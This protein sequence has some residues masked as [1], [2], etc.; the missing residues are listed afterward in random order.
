MPLIVF[1][2]IQPFSRSWYLG[3]GDKD[4]KSRS[5]LLTKKV[6]M[7]VG[8]GGGGIGKLLF[9][10]FTTLD[11]TTFTLKTIWNESK[12]APGCYN[13]RSK[14]SGEKCLP[15]IFFF[16]ILNSLN[17]NIKVMRIRQRQRQRQRPLIFFFLP[18]NLS[19]NQNIKV[20]VKRMKNCNRYHYPKKVNVWG[21]P[22]KFLFTTSNRR[23][24]RKM[25]GH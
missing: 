5:I 15:L 20:T 19:L 1:F 16:P 17:H 21:R 14:S 25:D 2:L 9:T 22:D 7:C 3:C 11:F 23:R 18:I 8:G 6:N 10:T 24:S 13:S 4:D 12:M